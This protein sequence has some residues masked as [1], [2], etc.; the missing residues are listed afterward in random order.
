MGNL[1]FR[2]KKEFILLYTQDKF[3]EK[4]HKRII[5]SIKDNNYKIKKDTKTKFK[6]VEFK[7][8]Y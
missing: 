5:Q 8:I 1:E 6:Y 2:V 7:K 4:F 3:L